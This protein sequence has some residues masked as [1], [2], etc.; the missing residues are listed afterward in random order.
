MNGNRLLVFALVLLTA[1]SSQAVA[2]QKMFF[3]LG[4]GGGDASYNDQLDAMLEALEDLPG[5]DHVAIS[6]D[7]TLYFRV[8]ET[9]MLGASLS[10]IGDRYEAGSVHMQLNQYLYAVSCR[11]YPQGSLGKGFFLRGDAGL[12]KMV[13][14]DDGD[15]TSSEAGFGA[16][17]GL[18]YGFQIGGGTWLSINADYSVKNIEDDTITG[19]AAGVAILF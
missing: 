17:A 7:L 8:N 19:V 16:L 1:A 10:G 11:F 3:N 9:T 2:G 13:L 15:L 18:G 6:L 4:F 14:D 12:A 5:V